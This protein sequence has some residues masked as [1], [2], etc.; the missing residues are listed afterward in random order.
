MATLNQAVLMQLVPRV[1]FERG[2][3]YVDDGRV[4]QM[5]REGDRISGAILGQGGMYQV[6]LQLS[7]PFASACTCLLLW[8][9]L[10][11]CDT[12]DRWRDHRQVWQLESPESVPAVCFRREPV[13]SQKSASLQPC[14]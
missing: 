8:E 1:I 12:V 6:W 2:S 13:S 4:Y 14:W 11:V 5:R 10:V 9:S 3:E 7:A